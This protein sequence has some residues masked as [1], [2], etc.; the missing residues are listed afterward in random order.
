MC[1][2]LLDLGRP[3]CASLHRQI[4]ISMALSLAASCAAKPTTFLICIILALLNQSKARKYGL[5][6]HQHWKFRGLVAYEV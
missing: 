3:A 6:G 4:P 1:S 2:E 5:T